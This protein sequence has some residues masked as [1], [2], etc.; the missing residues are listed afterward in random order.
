MPLH[1]LTGLRVLDV[2][3]TGSSRPV[4]VEDKKGDKYLVKLRESLSNPFASISDF[5][6]CK[7]GSS[8][9]LPIVKPHIMLLDASVDIKK[10]DEE[11]RDAVRKSYGLNIAY[12]F[13]DNAKDVKN[14][15]NEIY[16]TNFSDLWIFDVFL[17]NIDR[18]VHNTNIIE[19]DGRLISFDYETSMLI[20]GSLQS[21]D[22]HQNDAIL[23]QIRQNPLY[24]DDFNKEQFIEL[25]TKLKHLNLSELIGFLPHNWVS[26]TKN[27][28]QI[29]EQDIHKAIHNNNIYY[30]MM[31]KLSIITIETEEARKKRVLE[32]R[33]KFEIR[34]K[35]PPQ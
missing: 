2:M 31:D 26:A 14:T 11:V 6:A 30:E 24:T 23:K 3:K 33:K 12:P 8:I 7:I 9:G 29:L 27:L 25:T 34:F 16:K 13:F 10:V 32:N 15:K 17:L 28:A 19:A 22:F 20:L 1:Y 21:K 5:L 35:H 18:T 4:I